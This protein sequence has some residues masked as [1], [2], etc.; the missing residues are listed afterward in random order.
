V[1]MSFSAPGSLPATPVLA[2]AAAPPE[3]RPVVSASCSLT[4]PVTGNAARPYSGVAVGQVRAR[5][6][7]PTSC[8]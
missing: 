2:A 3:R 1:G 5:E 4:I 8:D 7:Y 6:D